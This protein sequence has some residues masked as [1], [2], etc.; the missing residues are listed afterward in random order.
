[1]ILADLDAAVL[2]CHVLCRAVM[3]AMFLMAW[4]LCKLSEAGTLS[5][6]QASLVKAWNTLRGR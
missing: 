4:R 3:Q 5:H 6:E 2:C 1:V